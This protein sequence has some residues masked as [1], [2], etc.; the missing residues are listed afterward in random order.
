MDGA[1]AQAKRE[2]RSWTMAGLLSTGTGLSVWALNPPSWPAWLGSGAFVMVG[3]Y[4]IKAARPF[5]HA[6]EH[7]LRTEQ[8][9]DMLLTLRGNGQGIDEN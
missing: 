9:C 8:P 4:L 1:V 5:L 2:A 6:V 7:L 3:L